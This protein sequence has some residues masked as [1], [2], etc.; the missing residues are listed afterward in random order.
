[1]AS[2]PALLDADERDLA[3]AAMLA[4]GDR[5]S[6]AAQR[7]RLRRELRWVSRITEELYQ[8][9]RE[10]EKLEMARRRQRGLRWTRWRA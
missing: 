9:G 6:G 7:A 4:L 5:K 3:V 10:E 2:V 8:E 1:M